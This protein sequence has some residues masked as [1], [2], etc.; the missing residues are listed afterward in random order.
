[1]AKHSIPAYAIVELL[2]R[3]SHYNKL[4]GDYKGHTI[5]ADAVLVKTSGGRINFPQTLIMRQFAHPELISSDEL[6]KV[7]SFFNAVRSKQKTISR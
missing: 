7:A 2:M 6:I 3:L 5:R 4:I 1:M